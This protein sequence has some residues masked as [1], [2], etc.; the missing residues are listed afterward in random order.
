MG[1]HI[2]ARSRKARNIVDS[3]TTKCKLVFFYR[4][5]IYKKEIELQLGKLNKITVYTTTN[6][7]KHFGLLSIENTTAIGQNKSMNYDKYHI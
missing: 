2:G 1:K 6:K 5:K 7:M 4:W 3:I